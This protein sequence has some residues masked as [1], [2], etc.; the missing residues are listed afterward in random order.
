MKKKQESA[1]NVQGTMK[2]PLV[3]IEDSYTGQE[4]SKQRWDQAVEGL[5]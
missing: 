3:I 5:D 4:N 2:K 1:V